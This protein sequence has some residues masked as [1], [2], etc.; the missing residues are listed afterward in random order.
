MNIL[1]YSTF[2][3]VLFIPMS[4]MFL[5]YIVNYVYFWNTENKPHHKCVRMIFLMVPY[6]TL[7]LGAIRKIKQVYNNDFK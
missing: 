4:I 5:G 1:A 6:S 3:L 2:L 7:I